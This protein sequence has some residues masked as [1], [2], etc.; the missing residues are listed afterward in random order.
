MPIAFEAARVIWEENH[1]V[2]EEAHDDQQKRVCH[3][4]VEKEH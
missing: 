3:K 1:P 4:K 2:L